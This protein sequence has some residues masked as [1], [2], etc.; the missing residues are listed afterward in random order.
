MSRIFIS[1]SSENN[2]EAVVL[3]DWLAAEGWD[4]VF[5]DLDPERGIAAGLRWE[6]ALNEAANR[7]EAV[8]FLISRA[9]LA[10]GWCRKELELSHRL[11]KR[12]FGVLIEDLE[13]AEIPADLAGDW[14][15]MRLGTGR[16][17]VMLQAV[18]PVTHK[19][20]H[21]TFSAEGLQRLK[22]GLERAG[23]DPK[24]FAWPP[25]N[26]PARPPYRGLRPLEAADAGILFGRDGPIVAALDTFRG[27]RE[28]TPP[29]LLVVLGASGAGKSSFLRAGLLPRL[30][31]DDRHFLPLPVIRPE[32]AALNGETGLVR[33]LE[34]ALKAHGLARTRAELRSVVA[35]GAP[36]LL[37]ILVG[38][39]ERAR[40]PVPPEE[41]GGAAP[42]LVIAV[43]QGEEL[44]QAEGAEEANSFLALL[45]ELSAATAPTAP[46]LIVVIT[47]RTDRYEPL[48]S[49]NGPAAALEGVE[50]V[51]FGL[52]PMPRGAYAQVIEGPADRLALREQPLRIDPALTQ[53]LLA[54]IEDGGAKDA[55]PLLAFTLE[56]LFLEHGADGTLTLDDY[57]SLGGVRG[58]V[59]AAV[60]QALR[61]ADADAAIPKD[62]QARLKLLRRGLIPW[63]AGIDPETGA[64]RRRVARLDEIPAEARPLIDLL[65]EQRLLATDFDR[66]IGEATIE[67]AHEALLRQWGLLEGWLEEE[68]GALTALDNVKRAVRDWSANDEGTAWLSHAGDRLQEAETVAA[69]A[70]FE[71]FLTATDRRYLAACRAT[72]QRR[73]HR[74]RWLN[75]VTRVAAVL[76]I[77]GAGVALWQREE[78][79][80]NERLAIE[81]QSAERSARQAEEQ[82]RKL[83]QQNERLAQEQ[84]K[85]AEHQAFE[86]R[87][88]AQAAEARVLLS[89]DPSAALRRIVETAEENLQ[90]GQEV[91]PEVYAALG[92]VVRTARRVRNIE[93]FREYTFTSVKSIAVSPDRDLVAIAGDDMVH[94]AD[95][96]GR[97]AAPP[98]PAPNGR[99][100]NANHVVWTGNG[101]RLAVASGIIRRQK[102]FGTALRLYDR[103]GRLVR[104]LIEDHPA[105]IVSL[106]AVP[107]SGILLAGDGAGNIIRA[108]PRTDA[109]EIV[110]TGTERP[111]RGMFRKDGRLLV[112][113]GPAPTSLGADAAEISAGTQP[114]EEPPSGSEGNRRPTSVGRI[115][116]IPESAPSGLHCL[117]VWPDGSKVA[118]CGANGLVNIWNTWDLEKPD[119]QRDH[120]LRGHTG[121][122]RAIA[123]HPG[124]HVVATGGDDGEVRL[125]TA[126]GHQLAPPLRTGGPIGALAFL[127]GGKQLLSGALVAGEATLWDVSDFGARPHQLLENFGF[128][129][130]S[131]V[132]NGVVIAEND[133]DGGWRVVRARTSEPNSTDETRRILAQSETGEVSG[134]A[135]AWSG[136]RLAWASKDGVSIA[137]TDGPASP[138]TLEVAADAVGRISFGQD[139]KV[140]AVA[141]GDAAGNAF[142]MSGQDGGEADGPVAMSFFNAGTGRRIAADPDAHDG[143]IAALAGNPTNTGAAFVSIDN[144]G[145]I[146]F[147]SAQGRPLGERKALSARPDN[148][149]SFS[150]EA[151]FSH[152]GRLAAIAWSRDSVSRFQ[153]WRTETADPLGP[154]IRLQG[155]VSTVAF[156]PHREIV[157][158]AHELQGEQL[159]V[160]RGIQLRT[161]DGRP[162]LA[163]TYPPDRGIS[164]IA[165]DPTGETLITIDTSGKM[166]RWDVGTRH[167]LATA[168]QRIE[169]AERI[170]RRDALVEEANALREEGE[171]QRALEVLQAAKEIAPQSPRV[172]VRLANVM[173]S[174]TAQQRTSRLAEYDRAV[175]LGPYNAVHYLQRGKLR[176]RMGDHAG[177]VEDFTAADRY[178]Y[179]HLRGTLVIADFIPINT[180]VSE[181]N[182]I[183]QASARIEIH[184]RRGRAHLAHGSWRAAETDFTSN[185]GLSPSLRAALTESI[186][187]TKDLTEFPN[188]DNW[189]KMLREPP[190]TGTPEMHELRAQARAEQDNLHGA[191]EDLTVAL[192]L[193]ADD[194]TVYSADADAGGDLKNPVRRPWKRA[195]LFGRLAA[196]HDRA[197]APA[198]A[199]EQRQH[200][201]AAF[202][203]ALESE[204]RN[205]WLL[206]DRGR[207]KLDAGADREAVLADAAAAVLAA[208]ENA[209]V[210]E[211]YQRILHW[212]GAYDRADQESRRIVALTE[213]PAASLLARAAISAWRQ[214]DAERAQ[215]HL[216][217]MR[218]GDADWDE[219][220]DTATVA[221]WPVERSVLREVELSI[222][223][224]FLG[225]D[226]R[227][228]AAGERGTAGVPTTGGAHI[229]GV[230]PD[231]PAQAAGLKPGD[232]IV[233][234]NG[235]DVSGMSAFI[236]RYSAFTPGMIVQFGI[237][238]GGKAETVPVTVGELPAEY[239]LS[240]RIRLFAA[241]KRYRQALAPATELAALRKTESGADHPRYAAALLQL[242]RLHWRSGDADAADRLLPDAHRI[243]RNTAPSEEV[244][245]ALADIAALRDEIAKSRSSPGQADP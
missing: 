71:G 177:A 214:D 194:E 24:Y 153:L 200:A 83:A 102:P 138:L 193:L 19:E 96:G 49:A 41:S 209:T 226:L 141:S 20:V 69:R 244:A 185:I 65:V 207:A 23:L 58:S 150:A 199:G 208:P 7:C 45:G 105:P 125:W 76:A 86:S 54:D 120:F 149:W 220:L 82:Q 211:R 59:E 234:L 240:R 10:S 229:V 164:S 238:R 40:P 172:S 93:N 175:A 159:S 198:K 145:A 32:Q 100:I 142:A 31:R 162:L 113:F 147:W 8:L 36:A 122:V 9:W 5:L 203:Q 26:D 104:S 137:S 213:A 29:R 205:P 242:A 239:A 152:D 22:I 61:A 77:I 151:A 56:R 237:L 143:T 165:F 184:R 161:F 67:P 78:A 60:E 225:A 119:L 206:L 6:R 52:P 103:Q 121:P 57:R 191:I 232:V 91:L 158:F 95:D 25:E 13:I 224:G 46:D 118:T 187:V 110:P 62:R 81:S 124:K 28:S 2:A 148:L 33:C 171:T 97:P 11:N 79:I 16:D 157:A 230:R 34:E 236:R 51:T 166:M 179:G 169:N 186:E 53:A 131:R 182:W 160:A 123:I 117:A 17:H 18:L 136:S 101:Q 74:E 84:K 129:E 156:H 221:L 217:R 85:A 168:R 48:Q 173:P 140:I 27:L 88:R 133:Y 192:R 66:E 107:D 114:D 190:E 70:A 14:Q 44:F 219:A 176:H 154:P 163:L 75:R 55:L 12:L 1:H 181:F 202:D 127:E 108:D 243:Y 189:R 155:R 130:L 170:E 197:G 132:K 195:W 196:L 212:Y 241:N 215:Q 116:P 80:R 228:I 139:D 35:A 135:A 128:D 111:I 94:I 64:P 37:P 15:L 227:D 21:V 178:W 201:V 90:A 231:G 39:A 87:L 3:R 180:L 146:R 89:V 38:L 134:L 167:L 218:G 223:N 72:E 174:G 235:R 73:V 30:A 245:K 144:M 115:K 98:I 4:D 210:S 92:N 99:H 47:I 63:L 204:P 43:D 106:L 112:A 222:D 42:T 50:Q 126:D 233:A 216:R 183:A 188:A 68:L 109:I